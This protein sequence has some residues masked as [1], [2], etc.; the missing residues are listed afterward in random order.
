M[1]EGNRQYEELHRTACLIRPTRSGLDYDGNGVFDA[2]VD[3]SFTFGGATGDVPAVGDWTGD[4]TSK[5][6]ILRSGSSW[7]LDTNGN[8]L[9]EPAVDATF[10]FGN[11]GSPFA[12]PE[13]EIPVVG[14][15]NGDG[16]SKVGLFRQ[17]SIW[18]LDANGDRFFVLGQDLQFTLGGQ[19]GDRPIVGKW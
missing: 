14:D 18:S 15:W 7:M 1:Q 3:K 11:F 4:G 8:G 17:G 13:V 19:P 12:A 16:K 5:I 2:S 6:G 9:Y 10:Q